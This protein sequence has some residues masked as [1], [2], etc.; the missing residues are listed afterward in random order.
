MSLWCNYCV[1]HF[2]INGYIDVNFDA[3]FE[4][5]QNKSKI[6]SI[7]ILKVFNYLHM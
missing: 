6:L 5:H 7:D 1:P 2:Y 3:T 4:G